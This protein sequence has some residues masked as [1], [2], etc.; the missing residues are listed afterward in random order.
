MTST[1]DCETNLQI[2]L[3]HVVLTVIMGINILTREKKK[4]EGINM[5]KRALN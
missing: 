3:K 2:E 4:E 1:Q 5:N